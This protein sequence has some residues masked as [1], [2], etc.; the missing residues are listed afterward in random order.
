MDETQPKKWG[1]N[2]PC[3]RRQNI[4]NLRRSR[5]N[6]ATNDFLGHYKRWLLILKTV[7]SKQGLVDGIPS[8]SEQLKHFPGLKM[9]RMNY[10]TKS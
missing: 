9:T 3:S 10:Q 8:R 4:C 2:L 1:F 6:D 5:I 7:I